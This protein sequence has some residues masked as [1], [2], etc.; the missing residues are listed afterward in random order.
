MSD[1]PP[2]PA[3][4]AASGPTSDSDIR[5]AME[6]AAAL[7]A[8]KRSEKEQAAAWERAMERDAE[9]DNAGLM[10][11]LGERAAK[12]GVALPAANTQGHNV[13]LL[14]MALFGMYKRYRLR[15]ILD[16]TCRRNAEWI[17][18]VLKIII[19]D[20]DDS[21]RFYCLDEDATVLKETVSFFKGFQSIY[22]IRRSVL[23]SKLPNVGLVFGLDYLQMLDNDLVLK[24]LTA[25]KKN[26]S[27][28]FLTTH[29]PSRRNPE[30]RTTGKYAPI[31]L[32]APPYRLGAPERV[33]DGIVDDYK[34]EGYPVQLM[35]WNVSEAFPY[36][37]EK[38]PRF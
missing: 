10:V 19:D 16:L 9:T 1:A 18:P 17:R 28:Y 6:A 38:Y 8:R 11:D 35:L 22:F 37:V 23:E 33:F 15:S 2:A 12:I 24:T 20:A 32:K 29:N 30:D 5:G 27:P 7:V 3:A 31:N 25:L 26:H 13:T 36:E 4:D 14:S 21:F 34:H